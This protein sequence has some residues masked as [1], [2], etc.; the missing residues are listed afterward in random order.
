MLALILSEEGAFDVVHL[1]E[2]VQDTAELII[3]SM[4]SGGYRSFHPQNLASLGRYFTL[5]FLRNT[6]GVVLSTF[7][8]RSF[9]GAALSS[10]GRDMLLLRVRVRG[11]DWLVANC[12]L[13]SLK[14]PP[15][16]IATRK[17]QLQEVLGEL[18][19]HTE[20]TGPAVLAGDLNIRAPEAKSVLNAINPKKLTQA[21][22]KKQAQ[23]QV[24]P[25]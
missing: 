16:R 7:E 25:Q 8:R 5:T 10:L 15:E 18:V 2:V 9:Q 19:L 12:H 4:E 21:Q 6:P 22:S 11:A 14:D 24:Q 17:A 3:C 1:Q 23:S 20:G 13:E